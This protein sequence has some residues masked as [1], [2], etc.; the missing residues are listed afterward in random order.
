LYTEELAVHMQKSGLGLNVDGERLGSPL[1]TDDIV[2]VSESWQE[3]QV[4]LDIVDGYGRY[5]NVKFSG[6]KSKVMVVNG[7]ELDKVRN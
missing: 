7:D 2:A 1:Y 5:F 4:M 3:L 6:D